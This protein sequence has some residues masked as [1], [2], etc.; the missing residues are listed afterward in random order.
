MKLT[1]KLLGYLNRVFSRDPKPFLAIRIRYAGGMHWKVADGILTTTVTGGAGAS[2][3]IDL[4]QYT[5]SGLAGFIAG[6]TGYEVLRLD[7]EHA[8]LSAR[9]LI[10]AEGDQDDSSGDHLYGYTSLLWAVLEAIAVQLG[11]LEKQIILA[12]DQMSIGTAEGMWID[13]IGGYFGVLRETGESDEVYGPRI[14]AEVVRPRSNNIAIESA[15]QAYTSQ[16]ATVVDVEL[17]GYTGPLYNGAIDYDGTSYHDSTGTTFYGLFDV[18]YAY[19]LLNGGDLTDF[20][21]SVRALIG[22][23]RAAGTHLRALA[24]Q[25]S[26]VNDDFVNAP[27]DS[28]AAVVVNSIMADTRSAPTETMSTIAAKATLSDALTSPTED[29]GLEVGLNYTYSGLRSYNGKIIYA[30]GTTAIEAI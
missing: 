24:L 29:A 16:V 10:D 12:P 18:A 1:K 7:S 2:L 28:M 9:V 30:G 13:E 14:I 25:T 4:S 19:D 20:Q 27:V 21:N 11:K 22:R 6:Q 5:L 15:I 26:A 17:P 3:T 8:D 23:L